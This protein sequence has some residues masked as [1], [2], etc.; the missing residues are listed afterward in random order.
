MCLNRNVTLR[1]QSHILSDLQVRH[2]ME[3]QEMKY[4]SDVLLCDESEASTDSTKLP[5]TTMNHEIFST[6]NA[7]ET[8]QE[9]GTSS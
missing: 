6:H 4:N 7:P 2:E 3:R 5:L 9:Q 8:T 1:P